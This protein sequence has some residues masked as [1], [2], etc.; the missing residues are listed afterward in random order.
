M[1]GENETLIETASGARFDLASPEA[2]T[3][4]LADIA[5][6]LGRICRYTGHCHG[7]C[8]VAEHSVRCSEVAEESWDERMAVLAL[9]HDAAEAYTGDINKPLKQMLG[10]RI[11][12]IESAIQMPVWAAMGIPLPTPEE[13]HKIKYVDAV[14]LASEAR[15][16][17]TSGGS[18]WDIPVDADR[19]VI[20]QCWP[21]E[22]A[23]DEF[24]ARAAELGI[25]DD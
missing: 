8:S 7:H 1:N 6:S 23:T 24:L 19:N 12:E 22:R 25:G 14:L 9:F 21:A 17:M 4:L 16:L 15:D 3:I 10:H 13:H 5:Y 11:V 20:A 2:E 18:W